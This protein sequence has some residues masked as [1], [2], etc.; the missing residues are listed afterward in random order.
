MPVNTQLPLELFEQRFVM[1]KQYAD[2]H[3]YNKLTGSDAYWLV[4]YVE[5]LKAELATLREQ[6]AVGG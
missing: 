1:T 5:R 4:A 3:G 2:E 6:S